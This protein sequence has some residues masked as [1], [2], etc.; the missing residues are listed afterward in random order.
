MTYEAIETQNPAQLEFD[1]KYITA[2]EIMKRLGLTR[3][4]LSYARSTNK[5]PTP[6]ILNEGRLFVWERDTIEPIL[7][8]WQASLNLRRGI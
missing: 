1:R 3:P 7:Q 4:V 2:S 8:A 5:L 6:I